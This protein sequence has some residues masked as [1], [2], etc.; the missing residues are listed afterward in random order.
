MRE[1]EVEDLLRQYRPAGPPL[2]LRAQIVAP[3]G[4]VR[5]AWPWIAAAAV[6]LAAVWTVQLSTRNVYQ[7]VGESLVLRHTSVL[8]N[9]PALQSAAEN[10]PLL[11]ARLEALVHQ[12]Q[13]A[14]ERDPADA[15]PLWR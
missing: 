7:Q 2:H 1:R 13:S 8:E 5:R 10:D 4:P 6:L 15:A 3:A 14:R 9:F 12:E 11:R